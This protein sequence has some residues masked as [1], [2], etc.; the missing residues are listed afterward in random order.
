MNV[1]LISP[2]DI[3]YQMP[4]IH[5]VIIQIRYAQGSKDVMK[6]I[7]KIGIYDTIL[8]FVIIGRPYRER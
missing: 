5:T 4:V 8:N 6:I 1:S 7:G 2:K 3:I